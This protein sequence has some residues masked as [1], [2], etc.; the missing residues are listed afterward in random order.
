M[1]IPQQHTRKASNQGITKN[2]HIGHCTHTLECT[3]LKVQNVFNMQNKII[4][5]KN[6]TYRTAAT[7]YTP[8]TW[9]VSGT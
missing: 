3:K 6:Y 1:K 4:Y 7:L 8:E 2:S 5:S 9:F